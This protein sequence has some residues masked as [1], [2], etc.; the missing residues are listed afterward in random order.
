MNLSVSDKSSDTTHGGEQ[1]TT[2]LPSYA[3]S[4]DVRFFVSDKFF[5]YLLRDLSTRPILCA[6]ALSHQQPQPTRQPCE[7]ASLS[8]A[9][10]I[11]VHC[12][13]R[14]P[15]RVPYCLRKQTAIP[16]SMTANAR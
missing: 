5:A 14:P 4:Q 7:V 9:E 11:S 13:E 2:P 12:E 15:L 16:S 1:D 8:L 6:T 10:A 3:T